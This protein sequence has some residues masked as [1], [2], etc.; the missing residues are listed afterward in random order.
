MMIS[1]ADYQLRYYPLRM[2]TSGEPLV[3]GLYDRLGY[4]L[5]HAH[6]ALGE[7]TGPAL[8]PL[9]I[10]GR[11]LAVLSV[12]GSSEALAQ[13]Q[14]AGRLGV[15]RTTMVAL[16]DELQGK[17]LVERRSDPLDRRRNLVFLTTKGRRTLEQG[18]RASRE[19]EERF[20][21]A[22]DPAQPDQ[23]RSILQRLL[24]LDGPSDE[25]R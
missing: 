12:L 19:A 22:L 1:T 17:H 9:G 4:L 23:L 6:L 16:V 5:K 10:N 11:E 13:Q 15:D 2:S 24:G 18:Q 7:H 14:A 8:A 20:L 3:P 21:A 25:T